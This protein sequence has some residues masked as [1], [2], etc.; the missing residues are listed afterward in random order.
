MNVLCFYNFLLPFIDNCPIGISPVLY[1]CAA[2]HLVPHLSTICS[3][4]CT[5][6]YLTNIPIGS[7]WHLVTKSNNELRYPVRHQMPAMCKVGTM[8]SV[9]SGFSLLFSHAVSPPILSF[10]RRVPP[11]THL[12]FLLA[13]PFN[14]H[15]RYVEFFYNKYRMYN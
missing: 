2:S 6:Y 1:S 8:K 14:F 10:D 15:D 13:T 9:P 5:R 7:G 12:C 11:F 4:H 3:G